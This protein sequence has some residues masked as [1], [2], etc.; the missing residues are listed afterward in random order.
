MLNKIKIKIY[1]DGADIQSI[2]KLNKKKF[3]KGF[4]TNPSLMR[5]AGINNY[6]LFSKL[7]LKITKKPISLEVFA[8]TEIGILDQARVLSALGKNVFVKIPIVFRNGNLTTQIIKTLSYENKNINITAV[9]T[10]KQI[11]KIILN[12]NPKSKTIISIF[13]G[14]IADTGTNPEEIF[15]YA[16]QL[17]KKNK[18]ISI[19]WASTREIFNIFQAQKIGA[20]IITVPIEMLKKLKKINYNLNKYSKETV[21]EF[22]DDAKKS[23]FKL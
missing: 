17:I 22:F 5:K 10:K 1:A 19:L 6:K 7:I 11:K 18:N 12:L 8:D 21:C 23:G 14:R 13:A 4:T 9:F 15:L 20:D 2:K 3:I 16:K